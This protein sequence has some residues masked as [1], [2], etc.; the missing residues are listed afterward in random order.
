M[1]KVLL[2]TTALVAMT[3][4]TAANADI[5]ISGYAEFVYDQP[6]NA[7]NT[8]ASDGGIVIK[9]TSTTDSGIT[10]SAVNDMKWEGGSINDAYVQASGDFGTIKMG[11]SDTALDSQDAAFTGRSLSIQGAGEVTGSLST[12]LIGADSTAFNYVSPSINGLQLVGS[13]DEANNR[14][15]IGAKYSIGGVTLG[16]QTRSSA[17]DSTLVG[18]GVTLAG[19]TIQAA[20]V[21]H[22]T[23]SAKRKVQD[24][25]FSYEMGDVTIAGHTSKATGTST[26]KNA[27]IGVMY[28]LGGGATLRA[29]SY[30]NTVSSVDTTG[31]YSELRVSF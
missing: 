17:T 31:V 19:V 1:R 18:A 13:I 30:S 20:S 7:D 23:G 4:V 29:T 21:E 3:G 27:E 28:A 8:M 26:D 12:V 14:T 16:Y 25:G 22:T 10:F 2:A 6:S 11:T 5:A 15:D 24:I 9:A